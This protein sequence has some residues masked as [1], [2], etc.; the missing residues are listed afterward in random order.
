MSL[1]Q[2]WTLAASHIERSK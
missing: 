1:V 2:I